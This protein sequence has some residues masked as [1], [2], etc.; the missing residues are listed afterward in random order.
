MGSVYILQFLLK[1][2]G[3]FSL[4]FFGVSQLRSFNIR[5]AGE[6]ADEP[7]ALV[8]CDVMGVGEGEST[9]LTLHDALSVIKG[10]A[11]E[12]HQVHI[13][14]LIGFSCLSNFF[15]KIYSKNKWEPYC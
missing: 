8:L 2:S 13:S 3:L 15:N 11:P 4:T 10:H 6:K 14:W 9:G 5:G 1:N 7:T 12:G